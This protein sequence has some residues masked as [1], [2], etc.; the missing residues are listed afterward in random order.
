MFSQL[1]P[2][3]PA[4]PDYRLYFLWVIISS[5]MRSVSFIPSAPM[6][7]ML[8]MVR[9]TSSSTRPSTDVTWVFCIASIADR[10]AVD[11]PLVTFRAHEGFA[12][13]HTIPARLAIMFF[14]EYATCSYFPPMRYVIPHAEP[15]DAT[16]HPHS[17][18]R[19]PRLCFI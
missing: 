13:S 2:Y 9:S 17:A 19:R 6:R 15:V 7:V 18:E 1:M 14:T 4:E 8:C 5:T 11:T 12:P 16:T 3:S 10:T